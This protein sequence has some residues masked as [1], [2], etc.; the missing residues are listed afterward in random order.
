M[1][2]KMTCPAC[3]AHLSSVLHAFEEGRPCP[4]CGL[5]SDAAVAVSKARRHH[6][7]NETVARLASAEVKLAQALRENQVLRDRLDNVRAALDEPVETLAEHY[8]GG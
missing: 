5:P 1:V 6:V 4:Q 3:E 8:R 7:E 2:A